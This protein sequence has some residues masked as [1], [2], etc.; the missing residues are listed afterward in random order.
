MKPEPTHCA[1]GHELTED[2]IYDRRD[3][4]IRCRECARTYTRECRA[5]QAAARQEDD[6]HAVRV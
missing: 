6:R 3:G 5:R 2:N 4:G 1:R